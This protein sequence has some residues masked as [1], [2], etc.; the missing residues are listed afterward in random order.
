MAADFYRYTTSFFAEV[1]ERFPEVKEK[2]LLY[3]VR[4]L[5]DIK[6]DRANKISVVEDDSFNVA[7][8]MDNPLVLNMAS[9]YVPGGG[10]RKG[11]MAQE[12]SLFYRSSYAVTL[13]S[14]YGNSPNYY[15]M[16]NLDAI[17]SRNVVVFCGI[18][19]KILDWKD[20]FKVACV[21]VAGI[22]RPELVGGKLKKLD[23]QLTK[24]K[25]KGI[26]KI[27]IQHKHQNLV[28]SAL[29]CGAFR[30]P[31]REI[32]EIFKEVNSECRYGLNIVFAILS[33]RNRDNYLAFKHVFG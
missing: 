14:R 32:A 28:L 27:A 20:C 16:G 11:A 23:R 18:D 25:I 26:Y 24:E 3:D 29:G 1:I 4:K 17:Y 13:D 8:K 19:Y 6:D 21:A 9:D 31:P 10:W 5:E 2:S 30:N 22:R 15:P 7:S 12:E 33:V